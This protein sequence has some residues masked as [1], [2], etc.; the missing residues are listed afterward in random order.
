MARA[1][2]LIAIS[3]GRQYGGNRGY[4][5]DPRRVYRFDS[6]VANHLQVI[7][8]DLVF[9]RNRNTVIG[10]A[11]IEGVESGQGAKTRLRCPTC[12]SP[13]IKQR[14]QREPP[15][16]CVMGHVFDVPTEEQVSVTNYEANYGNSFVDISNAVS[17]ADLKRAALRPSDQLSIEEVDVTV[18][19]DQVAAAAPS[20]RDLI[21]YYLQSMGPDSVDSDVGPIP[22]T[23][24]GNYSPSLAD[25]RERINRSIALR[26]GQRTFRNKLLRRYGPSCMITGCKLLDIVEAA[27]I[28]PYRGE[29]DNS[30]ENGI[31]LRADLHTLFDLD[32]LGINPQGFGVH[33]H[34]LVIA[35]GYR[36]LE[37]QRLH[38]KSYGKPSV[39]ALASRWNS[40]LERLE[41]AAD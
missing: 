23:T 32:L 13:N 36:E 16:R 38:L 9:I 33:V 34:P 30:S 6:S 17:V 11:R 5:D 26:R 18:F 41:R 37:G 25:T 10:M 35:A 31:L 22:I 7:A 4:E 40:F 24:D 2:A 3:E 28:W 27:H 19:S 21:A 1:W 14:Q 8:G 15:W 39:E 20:A 29:S 12:G